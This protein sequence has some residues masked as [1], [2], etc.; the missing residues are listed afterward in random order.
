MDCFYGI[1]RFIIKRKKRHKKFYCSTN[2][3]ISEA[4]RQFLKTTLVWDSHSRRQQSA[5]SAV[6]RTGNLRFEE[7]FLRHFFLHGK[8]PR[9]RYYGR[10]TALRLLVQP[11]DEDEDEQFFLP[12]FTSNGAPG[13]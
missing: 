4:V 8:G 6:C 1:R 2:F 3:H 7:A 12:S 11:Y 5:V 13:E 9:S 10:T